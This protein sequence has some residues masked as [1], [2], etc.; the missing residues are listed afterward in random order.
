MKTCALLQ[1]W[2]S[3]PN[4]QGP[5]HF[6]APLHCGAHRSFANVL[7]TREPTLRTKPHSLTSHDFLGD[8][9]YTTFPNS[10]HSVGP[11]DY[12]EFASQGVEGKEE[13]YVGGIG[14]TSFSSSFSSFSP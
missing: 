9:K 3:T 13:K 4:L 6:V 10:L 8:V 1:E 5:L 14:Y 11:P 12:V 2:K 7:Y